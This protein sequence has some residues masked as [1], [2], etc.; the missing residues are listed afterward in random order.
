MRSLIFLAFFALSASAAPA[1]YTSL[2]LAGTD[3]GLS[4]AGDAVACL[5][6][7]KDGCSG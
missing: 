1:H 4:V 6:T 2:R 3:I 5:A 7:C